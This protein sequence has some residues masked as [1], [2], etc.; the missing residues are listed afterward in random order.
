MPDASTVDIVIPVEAE[1]AAAL[2]DGRTRAAI[3]RL[4]SRVLRPQAGL[5]ALAVAIADMKAEARASDLTDAII[6]EELAAYNAERRGV[7]G[8]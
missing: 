8:G 4:V 2:A 5:S 6:D 3:G 7:A 1:A